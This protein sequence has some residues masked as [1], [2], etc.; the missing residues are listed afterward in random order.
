MN[1]DQELK[2]PRCVVGF[3]GTIRC[4]SMNCRRNQ[5]LGPKDDAET[6][7]Y[8]LAEVMSRKGLPWRKLSD[9]FIVLRAKEDSRTRGR[10]SLLPTTPCQH[11]LGKLIDYTDKQNYWN[12]LDYEFYYKIL[13][14]VGL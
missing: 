5:E 13:R 10:D 9:R 11:E 8:T 14:L 7:F 6:W 3:K 4:A 1:E 2:M 12:R